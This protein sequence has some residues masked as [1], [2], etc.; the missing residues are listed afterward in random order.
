MHE[1]LCAI[2]R[3]GPRAPQ[4]LFVAQTL[5]MFERDGPIAVIV[6]PEI[7]DF[8]GHVQFFLVTSP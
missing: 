8:T 4:Q 2:E 7:V 6:S 1:V 5:K 3:I